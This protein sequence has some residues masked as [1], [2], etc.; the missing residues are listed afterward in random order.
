[1]TLLLG[2]CRS[3]TDRQLIPRRVSFA[4]HRNHEASPMRRFFGTEIEYDGSRDELGFEPSVHALPL[5][6]ADPYLG[7]LMQEFLRSGVGAALFQRQP[8]AHKRREYD[9]SAAA[10]REGPEPGS[11]SPTGPERADLR[12]P[13]CGGRN[14]LRRNSRSAPPGNRHLVFGRNG[15]AD[16]PDRLA[17]GLPSGQCFHT[18]VQTLDGQKSAGHASLSHWALVRWSCAT[19]S[20]TNDTLSNSA[21]NATV[22]SRHQCWRPTAFQGVRSEAV[23]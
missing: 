23:E 22:H 15:F 3:L 18:R 8:A 11:G 14:N 16:F 7:E 6:G 10:S 21:G 19:P 1:M 17:P 4:H 20:R 13:S 2:L 5:V 9:C 12:P